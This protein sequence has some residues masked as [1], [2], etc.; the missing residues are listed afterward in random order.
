MFTL[1]WYSF[2]PFAVS[3][4]SKLVESLPYVVKSNLARFMWYPTVGYNAT[5]HYL[6]QGRDWYNRIGTI[7]FFRKTVFLLYIP[8]HNVF[9]P[10]ILRWAYHTRCSTI[11]DNGSQ[12]PPRGFVTTDELSF[13]RCPSLNPG[14]CCWLGV[15][16]VVNCCEEYMGPVKTYERHQ[17][18]HLH[19]PTVDYTSPTMEQIEEA[20]AFIEEHV[21]RGETVYI[22]CKGA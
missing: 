4:T 6:F 10:A 3:L 22:H 13:R 21:K 11:L 20:L 14:S 16:G 8:S 17:I 2:Y 1:Y 7:S 18:R 12:A 15:R 5:F 9:S 19:I